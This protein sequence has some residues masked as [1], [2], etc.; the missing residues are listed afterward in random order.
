MDPT[1]TANSYGRN[2][3]WMYYGTTWYQ[4]GPTNTKVLDLRQLASTTD[5]LGTIVNVGVG[6]APTA[7][8][9]LNVGG[10]LNTTG[11][12]T[13]TGTHGLS[14]KYIA[15]NFTGNGTTTTF[16][17][18]AG[19]AH[20]SNSVLVFLNGVLQVP[21]THY[22]VSGT[23]VVFTGAHIPSARDAIHIRELPL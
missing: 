19:S 12:L 16:A 6:V 3:G 17:L 2:M 5:T 11:N 10:N 21:G 23:N 15:S 18:T 9:K 20:T 4:F 8:I 1:N 22:N 14:A 7:S 13:V